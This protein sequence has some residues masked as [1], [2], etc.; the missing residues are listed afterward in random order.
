MNPGQRI[1]V[2]EQVLE[3]GA[4]LRYQNDGNL[5]L[6]GPPG[7]LWATGKDDT[8]GYTEMQHDGNLVCY[9]VDAVPYWASDTYAPGA[10]LEI[11][12]TGLRI[13]AVD[14]TTVWE[15]QTGWVEP[16][17]P[18]APPSSI[19]G[20]INISGQTFVNGRGEPC[21]P[22]QC[23]AGDLIGQALVLGY[24]HGTR[25]IDE[26][27]GA[28]YPITRCWYQLKITAGT[29]VP[30][31]TQNG[32]DPRTNPNLVQDILGYGASCGLK[33]NLS[34]GGIRGLNDPQ[35]DEIFALMRDQISAIGSEHFFQLQTSNE[36]RDT[37]DL[38]DQDPAELE[39]LINIVRSAHPNNLYSLTAYTGHEDRATFARY[40]TP[41]MKHAV[42][43]GSRAGH[44][45]DKY[46]HI[47]SLMREK[48][49]N[50]NIGIQDEPFGP[51]PGVSAMDYGHELREPGI[52]EGA[53]VMSL[54]CRQAW[55]FMSGS[56][57]VYKGFA[58][59]PGFAETPAI[60]AK[61]PRDLMT[62]STLSHSNPSQASR[63]HTVRTDSPNVREDYAIHD[64]GRF[65]AVRY[66]P[67]NENHNLPVHRKNEHE[68]ILNVP[69]VS[70]R[71]GRLV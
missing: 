54:M 55:T 38:D 10:H 51:P 28:Q 44:F 2:D 5:V 30:G 40:T 16:E 48:T 58:G 31:P 19:D 18:P 35:E 4:A 61:L 56:G 49:M 63:I 41:W 36:V 43:H 22:F 39:Q 34:G 21:L 64:D 8:P 45:W 29:W 52:M 12:R 42:V 27:V 60:V 17:H 25:I 3:N 11:A 59:I 24:D 6:Y 9:G 50:R 1:Y 15:V 53:A 20:P 14:G 33:W 71:L 32:W 37:G 70:V 26:I 23:H 69:G 65:A 67:P 13:I 47:F 62:F 68:V 7:A 66:G 46:R 57:V